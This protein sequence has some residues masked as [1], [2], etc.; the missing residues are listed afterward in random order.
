MRLHRI[1]LPYMGDQAGEPDELTI[2]FPAQD[3]RIIG[4]FLKHMF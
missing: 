1:A 2:P 3:G 4:K